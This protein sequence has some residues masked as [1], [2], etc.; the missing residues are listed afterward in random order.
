MPASL[1]WTQL[2]REDLLDIYLRI[3]TDSE[4]AAEQVYDRIEARAKTLV[5]Q[6]RMGV[7]RPELGRRLR[8]IN[9]LPYLILYETTPDLD[10][11][12]IDQVT[13]IRVLHGRR[14]LQ[15]LL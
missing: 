3:A 2:A 6:P 14:D 10:V 12:P 5:G 11:G 15:N 7:R 8:A 1:A 4:R 9:S 13:I